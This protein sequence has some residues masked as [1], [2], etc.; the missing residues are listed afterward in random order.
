M[1]DFDPLAESAARMKEIHDATRPPDTEGRSDEIANLAALERGGVVVR[2][3]DAPSV[4]AP[5]VEVEGGD[6][7]DYRNDVRVVRSR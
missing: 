2:R 1:A 6:R 5:S 7:R 3:A 4:T